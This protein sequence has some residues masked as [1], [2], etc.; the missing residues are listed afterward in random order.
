[1]M[2]QVF[3]RIGSDQHVGAADIETSDFADRTWAVY[4]DH[5]EC[6]TASRVDSQFARLEHPALPYGQ[7]QVASG[8]TIVITGTGPSLVEQVPVLQRLRKRLSIWTSLRGA[9]AL[10]QHGLSADL[11]L[12]QHQTDLDAYLSVRHLRDRNGD[13]PLHRAPVVLAEP[14]TPAALLAGVEPARVATFDPAC[15]WGH[16]PV[17]LAWLACGAGARAIALAGIDLGTVDTCEPIHQP[18]CSLLSLVA[19]TSPVPATDLGHGAIK[20]GWARLPLDATVGSTGSPDVTMALTPWLTADERR[21]TLTDTLDLLGE[22]VDAAR[23][24]REL[25]LDR[26]MGRGKGADRPLAES[27]SILQGWGEHAPVR[28]AFQEGLGVTFLPRLWRRQALNVAGPQWR[29]VLLAADQ[30]VRQFD[31]AAARV[32]DRHRESVA[33]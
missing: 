26:R 23:V 27:W 2:R 14:K 32:G 4:R 1:M 30:I 10:E 5:F 29:P 18:L 15:G 9:E 19:L 11:I 31:A 21:A 8:T 25:A 16:W 6:F 33:P 12:V 17:S 3:L 22:H 20:S 13:N 24:F 7:P 28:A